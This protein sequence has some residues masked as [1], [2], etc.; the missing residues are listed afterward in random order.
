MGSRH[1]YGAGLATEVVQHAFDP[2][3]TTKPIGQ[4]TGPRL[5]MIH[6]FARQS[7]GQVR[8][9]SWPD[10]GT[11]VCLGPPRH[12]GDASEADNPAALASAL[13]AEQGEAVL[14]VDDEPPFGCWSSTS[15][16]V[17]AT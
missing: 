7:G 16:R 13:R 15:S 17:S 11:T 9:N 4:G 1:I 6:G 14:I 10:N 3:F 12:V 2:F 5:S 8:I